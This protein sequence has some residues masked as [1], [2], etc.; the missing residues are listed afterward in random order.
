[1]EPTEQFDDLHYFHEDHTYNND[2]DYHE[3]LHFHESTPATHDTYYNTAQ[4]STP[5]NNSYW[6]ESYGIDGDY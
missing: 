2:N 6:D 4:D 1:M 3:D 5:Q